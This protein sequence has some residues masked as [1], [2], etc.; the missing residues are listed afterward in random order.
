ME[1]AAR[2]DRDAGV[3]HHTGTKHRGLPHRRAGTDDGAC[4]DPR[5]RRN[6]CSRFHDRLGIDRC[7]AVHPG[8]G[9][10]ERGGMHTRLGARQG[11]EVRLE[12]RRGGPRVGHTQR[13]AAP[14]V[15][16]LAAD[17]PRDLAR[18]EL[19][20][21]VRILDEHEVARTG[22][23]QRRESFERRVGCTLDGP[24]YELGSGLHGH[25]GRFSKGGRAD[26][27]ATSMRP[28]PSYTRE[29]Q[30]SEPTGAPWG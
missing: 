1:H 23:L 5:V 9:M 19:R 10:H 16:T 12:A 20:Q 30:A 14:H 8:V 18:T 15:V 27:T 22:V 21:V 4:A 25:H 26:P 28:A 3:E 13:G 6:A 7:L 29:P 2:S 24:A 11:T 17:H